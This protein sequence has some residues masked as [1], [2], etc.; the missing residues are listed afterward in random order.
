MS[1]S[2]T[3]LRGVTPWIHNYYWSHPFFLFQRLVNIRLRGHLE[4]AYV[5]DHNTIAIFDQ[6]RAVQSGVVDMSLGIASYYR[7]IVPEAMAALY[8]RQPPSELR[9]T[10]FYDLMREVHLDR[11]D[12]VYLANVG[13][14]PLSA[15]RIF[16]NVRPYQPL[17]WSGL[18]VRVLPVYTDFIHSLGANP[19][20]LRPTEIRD[21]LVSRRVDAYGWSYGGILDYG[22]QDCTRY[23]IDHP[24]YSANIAILFNASVWS[25]L[26]A[27]VRREL[28]EIGRQVELEAE[29]HMST[30]NSN[31]DSIL[32]GLG[33]EA[34]R[35]AD[36]D[37][38]AFIEL[39]YKAGVDGFLSRCEHPPA[40]LLAMI[41]GQAH[42]R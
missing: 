16:A 20:S 14:A 2:R 39:A 40:A 12:V 5:G 3:V 36:D 11:A 10:G 25:R 32:K 9:T 18:N 41:E 28:E 34:I 30:I 37:A 27:G 24:F 1:S 22:W 4:I 26:D 29:R 6:F 7:D 38:T 8:M 13:G 19:I 31:E 33:V 42:R 21:A 35:F 23:V 15:F 17:D